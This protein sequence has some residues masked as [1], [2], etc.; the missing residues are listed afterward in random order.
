MCRRRKAGLLSI[1]SLPFHCARSAAGW[2]GHIA[3]AQAPGPD[4]RP[5][6]RLHAVGEQGA[7]GVLG[8]GVDSGGVALERGS[9]WARPARCL[10]RVL[11]DL[12]VAAEVLVLAA[13]GLVGPKTS[14]A[15]VWTTRS[16][17]VGIPNGR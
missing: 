15:A 3:E 7:D 14:T 6:G 4:R 8:I 12:P 16:R 5:D 1:A 2:Q 9:G 10:L 11:Q 17:T 13:Q